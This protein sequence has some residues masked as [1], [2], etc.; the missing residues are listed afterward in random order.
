MN[1]KEGSAPP[2]SVTTEENADLI[3]ELIF[4]QEEG[5]HTHLAPHKIAKQT[6]ISRSSIKRMIKR[7]NFRQFKRVKSS[8][9]NDGCCNRRYARTIALAEKFERNTRMIE[10]TVQQDEK[11]FTLEVLVKLQNDRVYGKGKNFDVP[12]EN[13][14]ASTTM[15]SRKVMVSTAISW[16]GNTKPFF[17]N[18]NGIK[19][20]K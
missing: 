19:V 4:S 3:E 7:R 15:M 12:D 5:P 17:V 18:E 11:D 16:Y 9:M 6:G 1:R 20:N 13:F 8:E 2:R 14:F 10:E